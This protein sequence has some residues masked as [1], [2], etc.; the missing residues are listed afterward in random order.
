[1]KIN[2][3]RKRFPNP[4]AKLTT[5]ILGLSLLLTTAW[6]SDGASAAAQCSDIG[7]MPQNM[8]VT[9]AK[10]MEGDLVDIHTFNKYFTFQID[11]P[12]NQNDGMM[13]TVFF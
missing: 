2:T 1:M 7:F 12:A 4:L 11:R 13:K 5:A 3:T 9:Y 8:F 10:D 6:A